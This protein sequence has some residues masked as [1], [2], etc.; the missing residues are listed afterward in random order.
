MIRLNKIL[1][2]FVILLTVGNNKYS[3]I[4]KLWIYFLGGP[5]ENL[6]VGGPKILG[7]PRNVGGTWKA[8]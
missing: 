3:G 8:G 6:V 5:G 2:G 7:G 4:K 1:D